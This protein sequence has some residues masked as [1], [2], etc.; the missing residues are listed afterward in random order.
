LIGHPA[1]IRESEEV[2]V[3][4]VLIEEMFRSGRSRSRDYET[5]RGRRWRGKKKAAENE[6]ENLFQVRRKKYVQKE[7]D[8]ADIV[9]DVR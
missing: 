8:R 3:V 6:R 1:P 5:S 2:I 9:R 4:E 7:F